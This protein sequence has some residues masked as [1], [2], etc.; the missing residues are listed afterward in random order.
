M[1]QFNGSPD[2]EYNRFVQAF[3]E[4]RERRSAERR[5]GLRADIA[6]SCDHHKQPPLP[7]PSLAELSPVSEALAREVTAA[8][9]E[10]AV[11]LGS[12]ED[13]V[14][15][16]RAHDDAAFKLLR[17]HRRGAL[18]LFLDT[19]RTDKG[20]KPILLVNVNTPGSVD[21]SAIKRGWLWVDGK[22]GIILARRSVLNALA[23]K[24]L[25]DRD[26]SDPESTRAADEQKKREFLEWAEDEKK[27]HGSYPPMEKSKKERETVD[28]WA[29]RRDVNRDTAR[30]WA[31]GSGLARER[32]RPPNKTA[33]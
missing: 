26:Y 13:S 19:D 24:S 31:R 1:T 16:N 28:A 25:A 9:R 32:G 2:E 8:A 3:L 12:P 30:G 11:A 6:A 21:V 23:G 4:E 17:R 7:L 5:S 22:I 20:L 18:D 29:A 33:S 15:T 14:A 10:R 27:K